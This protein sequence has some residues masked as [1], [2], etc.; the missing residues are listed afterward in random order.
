VE[1]LPSAG[2]LPASQPPPEPPP[3]ES[4]PTWVSFAVELL[5]QLSQSP[6]PAGQSP[7]P[8][9][10]HLRSWRASGLENLPDVVGGQ[11]PGV[12]FFQPCALSGCV[13]MC[14]EAAQSGATDIITTPRKFLRVAG[15]FLT[16]ASGSCVV[17]MG[18]N[19][20][21][22]CPVPS[23]WM[24]HAQDAEWLDADGVQEWRYI[25]DVPSVA[26][27]I[28]S[29]PAD[30]PNAVLSVRSRCLTA[31]LQYV[32]PRLA[33]VEL[34]GGIHDNDL[35]EPPVP[36]NTTGPWARRIAAATLQV[37]VA[38]LPSVYKSWDRKAVTA[39]VEGH[40]G[41]VQGT[42]NDNTNRP[43]PLVRLSTVVRHLQCA[44]FTTDTNDPGAVSKRRREPIC[45]AC[46]SFRASVVRDRL[47]RTVENPQKPD[48]L[49][50]H[51]IGNA[52]LTLPAKEAAP[53]AREA[54]LV[55]QARVSPG[56]LNEC[57]RK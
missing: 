41:A 57:A 15:D 35:F 51:R 7:P 22:V 27:H 20:H 42:H 2:L 8:T 38:G 4:P 54:A 49:V 10:S 56:R 55:S 31:F 37:P 28:G 11:V 16:A 34:C 24:R 46:S 48:R 18:I 32:L 40:Y 43:V 44:A 52:E 39:C 36:C 17:T 33:A 5:A 19:S 45:A 14:P 47:K 1:A 29:T 53:A 9:Q 21:R 30:V 3:S 50:T 23:P 26:D 12:L 13:L 25:S 6:P